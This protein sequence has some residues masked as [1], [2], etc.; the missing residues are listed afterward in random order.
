MSDPLELPIDLLAPPIEPETAVE[1]V[2]S[3]GE[4]YRRR[5]L[6]RVHPAEAYLVASRLTDDTLSQIADHEQVEATRAAFLSQYSNAIALPGEAR[7]LSSEAPLD[8]LLRSVIAD[9]PSH[10]ALFGCDLVVVS[11]SEVGVLRPAAGMVWRRMRMSPLAV[12]QFCSAC[13]IDIEYSP[14][15]ALVGV[16]W[17]YMQLIGPRGLQR[18]LADVGTVAATLER[19]TNGIGVSWMWEFR[20]VLADA[21]LEYDGLERSVIAVGAV[22][23]GAD[24]E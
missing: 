8:R 5:L 1:L 6:G 7:A 2:W 24:G 13:G 3:P 18:C 17:R 10:R 22:V 19:G 12:D 20:N 21:A 9:G 16:P 11:N 15:L 14:A 4:D 23:G